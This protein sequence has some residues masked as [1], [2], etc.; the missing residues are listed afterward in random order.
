MSIAK[1]NT[2][3]LDALQEHVFKTYL[4]TP[5]RCRL[6]GMEKDLDEGQLRALIYFEAAITILNNMGALKEEALEHVVPELFTKTNQS[7]WEH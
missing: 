6:K 4:N 7:V 3:Y 2:E 1:F 5:S